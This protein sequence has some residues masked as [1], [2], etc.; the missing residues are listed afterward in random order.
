MGLRS[1]GTLCGKS[2]LNFGRDQNLRIAVPLL[3]S[4]TPPSGKS[5]MRVEALGRLGGIT[6]DQGN[7]C[8]GHLLL[9]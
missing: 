2:E 1:R 7:V 5:A 6:L 4:N 8:G 9:R 3:E